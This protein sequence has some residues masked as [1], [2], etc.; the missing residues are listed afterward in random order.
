MEWK[1]VS[2]LYCTF[3]LQACRY[4]TVTQLSSADIVLYRKSPLTKL[5]PVVKDMSGNAR[6]SW[7]GTNA[8]QATPC[9]KLLLKHFTWAGSNKRHLPANYQQDPSPKRQ[10]ATTV[11]RVSPRFIPWG[12]ASPTELSLCT[13]ESV[14]SSE[15]ASPDQTSN[16]IP[17]NQ[18]ISGD[19]TGCSDPD[20]E[21][22][23]EEWAM[24]LLDAAEHACLDNVEPVTASFIADQ[25][26]LIS[27]EPFVA[28]EME[29][30]SIE[31]LQNSSVD[32]TPSCQPELRRNGGESLFGH[33]GFRQ[34]GVDGM[35]SGVLT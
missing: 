12:Q 20:K 16:A 13:Y 27:P 23:S 26:D 17:A 31:E 18:H 22:P 35:I 28:E 32:P 7:I 29:P 8:K 30:F 11:E 15:A 24:T 34:G 3:Y 2:L 4:Y 14:H 5:A 9:V 10:R 6:W 21:K 1:R 33:Q 19:S 25:R